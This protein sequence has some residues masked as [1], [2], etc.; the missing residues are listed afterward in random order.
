MVFKKLSQMFT[1]VKYPIPEVDVPYP[2]MGK[3]DSRRRLGANGDGNG[4]DDSEGDVYAAHEADRY[5]RRSD[6]DE[7]SY[8]RRLGIKDQ[9]LGEIF[10][11]L[12]NMNSMQNEAFTEAI[13]YVKGLQV[14]AR[15]FASL[16][17]LCVESICSRANVRR[18]STIP[19]TISP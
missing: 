5:R 18:A 1:K 9:T 16:P 14:C 6:D 10:S 8:R 12:S 7:Y 2:V 15:V 19:S 13:Q 11:S 4:D 17:C 3:A